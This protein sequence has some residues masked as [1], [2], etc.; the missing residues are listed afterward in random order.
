MTTNI[1]GMISMARA[2][3]DRIYVR[4]RAV[5]AVLL[6]AAGLV[7]LGTISAW[8][9]E[10]TDRPAHAVIVAAVTLVAATVSATLAVARWWN[11]RQS[12]AW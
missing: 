10:P 3:A 8:S 7:A 2:S 1:P 12:R 6:L 5:V 4:V 11:S 9:P